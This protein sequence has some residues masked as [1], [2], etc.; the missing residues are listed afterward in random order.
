[1]PAFAHVVHL[2]DS[3]DLFAFGGGF[4]PKNPRTWIGYQNHPGICHYLI[5]PI[6]IGHSGAGTCGSTLTV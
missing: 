6:S 3:E 2:N 4:R 5:Q 1:M